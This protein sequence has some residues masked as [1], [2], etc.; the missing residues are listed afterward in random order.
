MCKV[1]LYLTSRCK[2]VLSSECNQSDIGKP[3]EGGCSPDDEADLR[4]M[5]ITEN[6]FVHTWHDTLIGSSEQHDII[7]S[8]QDNAYLASLAKDEAD[9][10]ARREAMEHDLMEW[11]RKVS[12]RQARGLRVPTMGHW[13]RG[14]SSSDTMMAVYDWEVHKQQNQSILS[15]VLILSSAYLPPHQLLRLTG[16]PLT[17]L[18]VRFLPLSVMRLRIKQSNSGDLADCLTAVQWQQNIWRWNALVKHFQNNSWMEILPVEG[19]ML[20]IVLPCK[21]ECMFLHP[22]L[23][24]NIFLSYMYIKLN[25]W[26][27]HGR[28]EISLSVTIQNQ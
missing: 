16:R 1:R 22:F 14:F 7:K 21:Y 10:E 5:L 27:N 23:H 6:Q 9:D 26:T 18:S 3:A 17:W 4:P 19:S 28:E 20:M 15:F 13:R 11:Q 2:P 12:L 24:W 8:E 25:C